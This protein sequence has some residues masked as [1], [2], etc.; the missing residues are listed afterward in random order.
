MDDKAAHQ[1]PEG[2]KRVV[3]SMSDLKG[4]QEWLL[5]APDGRAWRSPD[6]RFLIARLLPEIKDCATPS[7]TQDPGA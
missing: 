5:V 6:V 2:I 4:P 3:T 7:N 1:M